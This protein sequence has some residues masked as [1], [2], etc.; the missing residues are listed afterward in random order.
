MIAHN[1]AFPGGADVIDLNGEERGK[2]E[3]WKTKKKGK[4]KRRTRRR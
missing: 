3:G 1:C 4:R 2:E